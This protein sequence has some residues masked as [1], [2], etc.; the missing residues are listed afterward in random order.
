M[1]ITPLPTDPAAGRTGASPPAFHCDPIASGEAPFY[2]PAVFD[3]AQ[4]RARH[5]ARGHTPA[6]DAAHGWLFF[7]HGA[8]DFARDAFKARDPARRRNKLIS[9]AAMIVALIDCEDFL[10][11]QEPAE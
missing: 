1:A 11:Q 9:A 3:V 8:Q 7:W 6:S 4:L 5:I 10:A 2:S